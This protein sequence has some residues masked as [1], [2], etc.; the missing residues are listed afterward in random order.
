[1]DQRTA[2]QPTS[3]RRDRRPLCRQRVTQ[4]A[5]R[6]V[7]SLLIAGGM[8]AVALPGGAAP[9]DGPVTGTV[10]RDLNA[11]GRR[12]A[13]EPGQAGITAT[14]TDSAGAAST[15][16]T[17]AD[18]AYSI[19]V[20]SL[21]TGP[22]RIGFSDLPT[23]LQPAPHGTA[24]PTSVSR[25]PAGAVVDYGVAD[26]TSYCQVN[27]TLA[28]SCFVSGNGASSLQTLASFPS[29]AGTTEVS[30]HGPAGPAGW[31]TPAETT[32]A[33]LGQTGAI[34]G[35][36]WHAQSKSMYLGA[37]AKRFVPFGPGGSGAIYVRRGGA[38]TLFWS[39]GSAANRA[40]PGGNWFQDPWD[41]EITKFGWGDLEVIGNRLFAVN[42]ENRSLYVFEIDPATGAMVGNAPAAVLPIPGIARAQ[43]DARP[44]GLGSRDG[45][46]YVGGVDSGEA[47]GAT[48]TAWILRFDP[49]TSS[50]ASSPVA[51]FGLGFERG[52]AYR[53]STAL[54]PGGCGPLDASANWRNWGSPPSSIDTPQLDGLSVTRVNRFQVNPQPIL[55]DIVFDD[56]GN[57]SVGFRDRYG[58]RLAREL[59]IGNVPNP[60]WAGLGDVPVYLNGYSFGDTL[61]LARTGATWS[62]ENNGT[63]GG[64][65]GTANGGYGPGGGEFYDGDNSLYIVDNSG[66]PTLEG[67]DEVNMGGLYHQPGTDGV[68]TTSYDLFG[69]WDSLGVRWM[70]DTGND[71]PKG[72]DSTDLNT[73]GYSL[74]KGTLGG[75]RPFGKTN[76][77][78]DLE[79]MCDQAPLEIG[80]FVWFDRNNDG[81]QG[82]TEPVLPGVAVTLVD[83]AG[84]SIATATT[85]A[86]GHYWFVGAGAPNLPAVPGPEY[87]IVSGGLTPGATYT[88]SFDV[89]VADVSGVGVVATSLVPTNADV[90]SDTT[91]S[92]VTRVGIFDVVTA[93]LGGP[94]HNDHSFDAGFFS[95]VGVSPTT[96]VSTSTPGSTTAS[97][98]SIP[99][100]VE[101]TVQDRGSS[102]TAKVVVQGNTQGRALALTGTQSRSMVGVGFALVGAGLIVMTVGRRRARATQR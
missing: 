97:S 48:P 89:D 79:A 95:P 27:P 87:G 54:N 34:Y 99:T 45:Q 16:T 38:P 22:F 88:L 40:A 28:L 52:C 101:P 32:M 1:M 30:T 69:V 90:G 26:P 7:A 20:A 13:G 100:R 78:G 49:A 21:G 84:A 91:D 61:R 80:D 56:A 58:D 6:V 35:Q 36:G 72:R 102:T 29:S 12:D 94:G 15:A 25:A 11:N 57:M 82:P 46:L 62:L 71:A 64:V 3:S 86:G 55:S 81:V 37:F 75:D 93:T 14:A 50:F 10:Y 8:A 44:F 31:D 18:G 2:S 4:P 43:G 23:F 41:S 17:G 47:G 60:V 85:D 5:H 51:T 74:W 66:V 70:S 33:T 92:D 68:A 65:T 98:S 67:H 24:N 59:P 53:F 76:G 63:A 9:A 96:V 83:S 73:R 19:V 42:L 39:T 77:L